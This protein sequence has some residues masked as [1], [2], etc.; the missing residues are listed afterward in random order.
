MS[1]DTLET[2]QP[3]NKLFTATVGLSLLVHIVVITL[4]HFSPPDPRTLFNRAPL[5][6]VLVN[7]RSKTA[8]TKADVLAQAN[9]DGGGNTDELNR[10]IKTPLPPQ[11]V[12]NP[13]PELQQAAKR[14]V[15]Q[16]ARLRKLLDQ[17]Q[18]SPKLSADSAKS[19]PTPADTQLDLNALRQQATEIDRKEGEIARELAAYQTRPRKAFVGARAKGVVEARY[20]DDWRIKVERIGTLNYPTDGRGKRLSGKLLITV[21][22]KADGSLGAVTIDRSSGNHELDEA[23][24]RILRMAAPFPVLPRGI[25]DDTGKPADILSITRAWTFARGDN[26]MR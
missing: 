18:N 4:V 19:N 14:Q 5:E 15:E 11:Q 24:K 6:I 9:L 10:R 2:P 16:E 7:A 25:L 21:E 13:T 8:P 12:E 22:I 20:V 23:A 3:P 1:V 17:V 26:E